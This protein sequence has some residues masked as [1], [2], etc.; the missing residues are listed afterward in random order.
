MEEFRAKERERTSMSLNSLIKPLKSMMLP[1]TL[2]K[3]LPLKDAH[4]SRRLPGALLLR[5]KSWS[6]EELMEISYKR[7]P[8]LL[9]LK[10]RLS[11]RKMSPLEVK[12]LWANLFTDLSLKN[13]TALVATGLK[14]RISRPLLDPTSHGM[15]LREAMSHSL[16][17]LLQDR[18]RKLSWFS[19]QV[20]FSSDQ[21]QIQEL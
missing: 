4:V 6:L 2:G 11:R 10:R 9:I 19:T 3:R 15:S 16:E 17:A 5:D 7:A 18:V 13:C 20:S 14:D 12:W 1:Q 8:I 21:I